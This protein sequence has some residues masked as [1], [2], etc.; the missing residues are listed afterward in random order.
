MFGHRIERIR[1]SRQPQ[2]LGYFDLFLLAALVTQHK[3]AGRLHELADLSERYW[4]SDSAAQ[5][6]HRWQQRF[7]TL[8]LPHHARIVS[9]LRR[10]VAESPATYS[11][12][13]EI[14]C[15]SGLVVNY[16]V[17]ELP[18][19]EQFVGL[20][21]SSTQIA[22][23]RAAIVRPKLRYE[24]GEAHGWLTEHGGT[25]WII[26]SVGGVLEYLAPERLETFLGM[27]AVD[28]RPSL[29]AIVEALAPQHDLSVAE[30]SVIFAAENVF[31]HN[32]PRLCERA[33][34]EIRFTSEYTTENQRW[35]TLIAEAIPAPR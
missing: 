8:F 23:N 24:A 30:D 19:I 11:T 1:Q 18:G 27:L 17:D 31:S 22:R 21:L 25:G 4:A 35:L 6:H 10:V 33:G 7:H 12:L 20:D 3:A 16:L 14:G 13:C 29:L 15:G 28:K 5:Y 2:H 32:Y 34:F 26:F 9:T